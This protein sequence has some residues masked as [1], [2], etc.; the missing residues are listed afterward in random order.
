MK[1]RQLFL[2]HYKCGRCRHEWDDLYECAVDDDCTNCG[3]RHYTPVWSA[4]EDAS[5][6]RFLYLEPDEDSEAAFGPFKSAQAR[7]EKA[8][9]IGDQFPNRRMMMLDL[10][11][12]GGKIT[13]VVFPYQ[14]AMFGSS[15]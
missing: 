11:D 8:C 13:P 9:G 5:Y 12:D 1:D 3:A 2:N 10:I 4:G 6:Q 15:S 14:P 7:D